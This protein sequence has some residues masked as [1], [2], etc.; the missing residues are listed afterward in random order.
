MFSLALGGLLLAAALPGRAQTSADTPA[1]PRFYVG[2]SAYTS[3]Y[4]P[5]GYQALSSQSRTGFRV[6]VQLTAGYQLRP[7]LAVQLGLVSTSNT[8]S[9]GF[10]GHTYTSNGVSIYTSSY[11]ALDG[12]N[13]SRQ[14]SASALARYTLTRNPA[15]RVQFDALG[16]FTLEHGSSYERGTRADSVGAM[17]VSTPFSVRSSRNN[18]L[19]T[20]GLG[21]RVRLSPRFELFY[22]F[23]LNKNLNR[24]GYLPGTLTGSSA[25]GLRYRFGR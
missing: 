16:G 4:Q 3:L 17:L 11:F 8:Y 19:L 18:L 25:L 2:L 13:T 9:Y 7:R 15:H 24:A 20:A 23:T 10:A 1:A 21:T 5:L 22:D 14:L 12:A 6:P